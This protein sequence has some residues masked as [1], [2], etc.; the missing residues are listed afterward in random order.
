MNLTAAETD[1]IFIS[2]KVAFTAT[3]VSLPLAIAVAL[4]LARKDFRGKSLVESLIMAPLVIPPLVTGY[5][6][7]IL[8]GR[9][10]PLGSWL[11][12][13]FGIEIAFTWIGAVIAAAVISFPL[14]VRT[15]QVSFLAIPEELEGVS[16]TLGASKLD[17]LLSVTLP[18][19]LPGIISAALLGFARSLGEFGAT[20][21][22]A[23]N[24]P[25]KTQTIP[26][27]IFNSLNRPGGD[28]KVWTL[29]LISLAISIAALLI[30]QKINQSYLHEKK[31]K[32]RR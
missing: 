27:A 5:L 12:S 10:G 15:L 28:V 18:L 32:S 8:L 3:L 13:V 14:M 1:A 2:L 6:L 11:S 16:R 22:I 4:I 17:C 9:N 20:I 7:L 31:R 25:G 29:V 19:A 21:I 24:L 30:S 26:L 23:G